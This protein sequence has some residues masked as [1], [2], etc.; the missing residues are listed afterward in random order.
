MLV[1]L[2]ERTEAVSVGAFLEE[3]KC[4]ESK[5][6]VPEVAEEGNMDEVVLWAVGKPAEGIAAVFGGE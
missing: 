5:T 1:V 3:R 6:L 4:Q 2:A